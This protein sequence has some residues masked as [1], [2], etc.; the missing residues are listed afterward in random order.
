MLYLHVPITACNK[1]KMLSKHCNLQFANCCLAVEI[2]S[3]ILGESERE[4]HSHTGLSWAVQNAVRTWQNKWQIPTCCCGCIIMWLCIDTVVQHTLCISD[5]QVW[6]GLVVYCECHLAWPKHFTMEYCSNFESAICEIYRVLDYRACRVV[7][8]IMS[9]LIVCTVSTRALLRMFHFESKLLKIPSIYI[10]R[11][12]CTGRLMVAY[13]L[14]LRKDCHTWYI[15]VCG[16][17]LI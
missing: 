17:G 12:S 10:Y 3:V 8:S 5:R 15:A 4:F 14:T 2:Q 13:R 16:A 7:F 6:T 11:S 9:C 1:L